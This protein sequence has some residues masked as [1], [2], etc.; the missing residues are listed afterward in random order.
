MPVSIIRPSAHGTGV[1][2]ERITQNLPKPLQADARVD[3]E[4]QLRVTLP[5]ETTALR[6]K[7][8]LHIICGSLLAASVLNDGPL[9][10]T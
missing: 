9:H 5:D 7:C 6:S 3:D 4:L 10:A 1:A 2:E 8:N